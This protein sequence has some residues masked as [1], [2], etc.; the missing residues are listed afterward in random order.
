MKAMICSQAV[1]SAAPDNP[2][3]ERLDFPQTPFVQV[4]ALSDAGTASRTAPTDGRCCR[5]VPSARPHPDVRAGADATSVGAHAHP[6]MGVQRDASLCRGSGGSATSRGAGTASLRR[7]CA[8]LV[9]GLAASAFGMDREAFHEFNV[10]VCEINTALNDVK[11][12]NARRCEKLADLRAAWVSA[13]PTLTEHQGADVERAL[14]GFLERPGQLTE[15]ELHNALA[16]AVE[17]KSPLLGTMSGEIA[18]NLE[19]VEAARRSFVAVAAKMRTLERT[20]YTLGIEDVAMRQKQR[21]AATDDMRRVYQIVL[22]LHV[23]GADDEDL[24]R[25]QSTLDFQ[26]AVARTEAPSPERLIQALRRQRECFEVIVGQLDGTRDQLLAW[27]VHV[28]ELKRQALRAQTEAAES[29]GQLAS[30]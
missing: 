17:T 16:V 2:A 7:L 19:W 5:K 24:D 27:Q 29:A 30:I 12:G 4:V 10:V 21:Q 6:A 18:A 26:V 11:A 1:R 14:K 8:I 25:I 22:L 23:C 20:A 3:G 9:V 28:E 15:R 13:K